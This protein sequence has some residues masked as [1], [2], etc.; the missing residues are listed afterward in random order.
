MISVKIGGFQRFSPENFNISFAKTFNTCNKHCNW[1]SIHKF[2]HNAATLNSLLN[3]STH[4]RLRLLTHSARPY[5]RCNIN[6]W[7]TTITWLNRCGPIMWVNIGNDIIPWNLRK[8]PA[9]D[10]GDKTDITN[11]ISRFCPPPAT[12]KYLYVP[13]AT[14]IHSKASALR[15]TLLTQVTRYLLQPKFSH[16][17]HVFHRNFCDEF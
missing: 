13:M 9:V 5:P 15:R 12:R 16:F 17:S 11:E 7:I 8:S 2:H 4:S 10:N 6:N 1:V 14:R 3:T